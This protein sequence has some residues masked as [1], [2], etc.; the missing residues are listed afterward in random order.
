MEPTPT[1]RDLP[2]RL[3]DGSFEEVAVEPSPAAAAAPRGELHGLRVERVLQ[4][5]G[6]ERETCAV[7]LRSGDRV[8]FLHLVGGELVDA[9]TGDL[10]G[11]H[12][13]FRILSWGSASVEICAG[14]EDRE[15]T[16]WDPLDKVVRMAN[17][18]V[19]NPPAAPRS[20]RARETA[21]PGAAPA[22]SLDET[23]PLLDLSIPAAFTRSGSPPPGRPAAAPEA[24][25]LDAQEALQRLLRIP[26]EGA[27]IVDA[28]SGMCLE[29]AGGMPY[30]E[31][32]AAMSMEVLAVEDQVIRRMASRDRVE[33]VLVTL[34][35]QHHVLRPLRHRDGFCLFVVFDR[36]KTKLAWARHRV[37]EIESR[38]RL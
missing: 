18:A 5:L 30:F 22:A 35:Q 16:I 4:L 8:G 25:Q 9:R 15:R 11:V 33:D 12:A 10:H 23:D 32:V 17:R 34:G 14:D 20:G 13:A 37:A 27:A 31:I 28:E 36:R 7:L 3:R 21:A 29:A 26:A 1:A 2:D 38:L 24:R 6:E 19:R